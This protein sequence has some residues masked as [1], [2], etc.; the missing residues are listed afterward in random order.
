MVRGILGRLKFPKEMI[1]KITLLVR[2]HMFVYDP[3]TVTAKGVRR[4]LSRVGTENID[5]L[6][7]LREADRIGS[8]VPKAQPYRLRH[9]QAMIEKAKGEPVSVKQLKI[10]GNIMIADLGM[11]PG[12]KMGFALAILLEEVLDDPERN[13]LEYLSERTKG[14]E[15][16]SEEELRKLADKARQSAA[17]V[18]KRIDDTIKEKYFVK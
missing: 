12:P 7:K 6:I 5:D 15:G 2:E 3:E 9:L 16:L 14:L 8:G 18:Q 13:T 4:L 17:E 10:D 1:S 11:K